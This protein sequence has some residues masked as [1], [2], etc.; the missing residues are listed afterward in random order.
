M[1]VLEI[2]TKKVLDEQHDA[3]IVDDDGAEIL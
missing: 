1:N 2:A 3:M